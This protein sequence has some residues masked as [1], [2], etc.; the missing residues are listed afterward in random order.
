MYF[1]PE[2]SGLNKEGGLYYGILLYV[3]KCIYNNKDN[4]NKY[5]EKIT[6]TFLM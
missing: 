3:Y 6:Q 5:H 1:S 4:R 2:T